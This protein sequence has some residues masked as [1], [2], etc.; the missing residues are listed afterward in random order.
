MILPSEDVPRPPYS[1][2]ESLLKAYSLAMRMEAACR[3]LDLASLSAPQVGVPWRL[4][5]YW[6][7]YPDFPRQFSYIL[8]CECEGD[9]EKMLSIEGCG[10]FPGCRFGIERFVSISVKGRLL[11]CDE[12]GK[13]KT[14][15]INGN[16][17]GPISAIIQHEADHM[18]GVFPDAAGER[19]YLK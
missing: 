12:R 9:G 15:E 5:V 1:S 18:A 19:I 11:S 2:P 6:S 10:S 7:N 13:I 8:D 16:F 14:S 17:S 4:F 3:D